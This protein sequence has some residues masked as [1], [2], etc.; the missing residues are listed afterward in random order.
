MSSYPQLNFPAYS[1]RLRSEAGVDKVWDEV[2][3]MW[4][5]LTPEEWVRRHAVRWLIEQHGV[6]PQL[7]VQEY[8][9]CVQ[10][11]PQRADIVVFGRQAEPLILVECKEPRVEIDA[12]VYAQAVRYNAVVGAR[13][14]MLTNGLKHYLYQRDSVD[15]YSPL[16]TLPDLGRNLYSHE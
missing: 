15:G 2:R 11:Q 7:I 13:Y 14:V 10:G 12:A 1:F 6:A 9:V 3:R 5:V 4:L 8:P 16:S